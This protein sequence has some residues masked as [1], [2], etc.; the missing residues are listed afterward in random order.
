[1]KSIKNKIAKLR[2]SIL[3]YEYFYHTLDQSIISDAE[4]DYLLNQLY[5]LELQNKKL[6]TPDSPT[7][8]V[9]SNLLSKFKQVIHF[10]PMLS[11]DNTFNLNGYLD[12]EKKI[13][14][15]VNTNA[16]ISVCC[17][18][19][20]D[21]V[22]ISI[23]YEEGI[24][25]RA[26]T[27]GDGIK[28]ENITS[29]ARM[30]KSIPMKLKGEKIPERLEVRGEVFMLKSDFIT[31][32][33][34]SNFN[35]K[36]F[37]SNP[38]N[39]ASGSLRHID[40]NITNERKLMFF[41]H[42]SGF[43]KGI[44]KCTSHYELLMKYSM[45]G[46]PVNNN[47]IVCCNYEEVF[48][49]YKKFENKR[50]VLDFDID[51]I[52]IKVNS[53]KIQKKL[54]CTTKY[55]RW[56]IAFKFVSQEKITKL[57]DVRFQVGRTGVITPVA[58]FKPINISGVIIRKAS[59]HNKNEIERLNLHIGDSIVICRSGDVIPKLLSVIKN[60]RDSNAKKIFFPIF[61]PVCN[62]Q[63][64]ENKEEKVIR[65]HSGLLCNAQKKKR[66][67][68]FFSKNALNAEGLGPKIINELIKKKYVISPIDFFYLT[69]N[70]L[71]TLEHV[72]NKKSIK[73]LL[74]IDKCKKTSFK[75]FIYAL[76]IPNVG[77]VIAEK[78]ANYFIMLDP[79]MYAD[80]LTL[81]SINGIGQVISNN[82]FNYF[83][84]DENRKIVISLVRDIGIMWNY[85]ENVILDTKK[86]YFFEKKIVLTGIFSAFSRTELKNILI[87]LGANIL[88]GISKN[89]DLLIYGKK[90]GKKFFK[91]K[92]YKINM[93]NEEELNTLI[94]MK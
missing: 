36:K 63:L 29:N 30:I 73:I 93:I 18:L 11:L 22:A 20:I 80:I 68:H 41:C 14:K 9:G 51:G 88:S 54:G 77:E 89:V 70:Q 92:D 35:D 34:K 31:L 12:F 44:D 62:T 42:G 26:A 49:F 46:L 61:C 13:K 87:E 66:L 19:K 32:N 25:V 72:G 83:S 10:S 33:T 57:N 3:T 17:E 53:L 39:A 69:H 43:F 47:F 79:L 27:R 37:F 64:L 91:A 6:I 75:R 78:L 76:G 28:G 56:A 71:I 1:M 52:V 67:Y 90:F 23:I 38:R 86:K 65:C 7:Q 45:W 85:Q 40:P 21:G 24:F 15:I 82:I 48:K 5:N 2:E 8:K 4:Y 84:T 58:Y 94:Q 81:N 16:E 74:S 60:I 55:P 50:H 59:L